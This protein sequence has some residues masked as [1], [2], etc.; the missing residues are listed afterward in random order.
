M[1]EVEI[2][3]TRA[4]KGKNLTGVENKRAKARANL[5]KGRAKKNEMLKS[6]REAEENAVDVDTDDE[7]DDEDDEIDMEDFIVSKKRNAAVKPRKVVKD[8][9]AQDELRDEMDRIKEAIL[10]LSEVQKKKAKRKPRTKVLIQ[11]VQSVPMHAPVPAR[12]S[13]YETLR[14]SILGK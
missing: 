12:S 13:D 14:R 7:S 3:P 1:S 10:K 5:A 6:K 4:K 11:P 8:T 9:S 2:K